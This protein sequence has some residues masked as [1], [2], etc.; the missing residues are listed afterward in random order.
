MS[1]RVEFRA[2]AEQ[3]GLIQRAALLCG[4]PVAG[5]VRTAALREAR[6]VVG[7]AALAEGLREA[8]E[9]GA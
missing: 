6:R 4:M 3:H 7:E 1:E 2:R 5:F 9:E 8:A